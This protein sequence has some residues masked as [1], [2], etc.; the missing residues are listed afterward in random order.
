MRILKFF[1]LQVVIIKHFRGV[2][3]NGFLKKNKRSKVKKKPF[4]LLIQK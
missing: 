4:W 1:F 3:E 2:N